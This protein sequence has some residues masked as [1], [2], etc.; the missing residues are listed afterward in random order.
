MYMHDQLLQHLIQHWP[1]CTPIKIDMMDALYGYW[2]VWDGE[3]DRCEGIFAMLLPSRVAL[4]YDTTGTLL[5]GACH[6]VSGRLGDIMFFTP[7]Y[8]WYGFF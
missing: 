4:S 3:Y 7:S 2:I 6:V 5:L 8:S 1:C